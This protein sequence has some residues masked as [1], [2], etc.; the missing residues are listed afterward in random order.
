MAFR[1]LIART[2]TA[3]IRGAVI[4]AEGVRLR[5]SLRKDREEEHP[6]K[7]CHLPNCADALEFRADAVGD[8]DVLIAAPDCRSGQKCACVCVASEQPRQSAVPR[9]TRELFKGM[10][11]PVSK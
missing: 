6:L 8:P 5:F 3:A 7:H 4:T 11:A 1:P 9:I 10:S 2:L